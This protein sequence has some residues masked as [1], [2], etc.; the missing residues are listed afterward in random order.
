[1]SNLY[2]LRER[3][4]LRAWRENPSDLNKAFRLA[5]DLYSR[6]VGRAL[7]NGEIESL[8]KLIDEFSGNPEQFAWKSPQLGALNQGKSRLAAD[9][10]R[11][12]KQK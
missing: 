6:D 7:S 8:N 11:A 9:A 3:Y 5:E 2:E 10:Y 4:A 12:A 1:M